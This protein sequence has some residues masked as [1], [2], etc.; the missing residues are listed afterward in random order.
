M[1]AAPHPNVKVGEFVAVLL[2]EE[3]RY[4]PDTFAEDPHHGAHVVEFHAAPGGA[5]VGN[6]QA[7]AQGCGTLS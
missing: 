3:I 7:G 4:P 1:F 5:Q 6:D 2:D